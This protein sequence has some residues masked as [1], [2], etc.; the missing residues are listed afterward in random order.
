MFK[1]RLSALKM[2]QTAKML[3][4]IMLA[5]VGIVS[6]VAFIRGLQILEMLV[7]GINFNCPRTV[8]EA[9]PACNNSISGTWNA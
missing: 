9:L 6:V 5:V 2:R 8:P 3:S 1:K 7:L 4:I